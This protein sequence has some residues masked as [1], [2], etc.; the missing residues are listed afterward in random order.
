M[1]N[2]FFKRYRWLLIVI[3]TLAVYQYFRPLPKAA[4]QLDLPMTP[5]VQSVNLAWPAGGQAALGAEGYGL[6]ASHNGQQPAP[7]GSTA[8]IITALAILEQ[9]PI[10]AGGQGPTLTL[11]QS[12]VD[13][14]NSYY[15]QNGSVTN[16]AAGEQI[17]EYQALESLLIPSS[18]NM[19]DTLAAWA[20]GSKNAYLR[21][22]NQ[23]VKNIGLQ[24]TTV[25]DTNGFSDTTTSTADDLVKL[26]LVAIKNPVF[27]DV[28]GKTIAQ[29][30]VEGTIKNTNFLL[31][32]SGIIGIKTGHTDQAGGNYVFAA[33]Q[34]IQGHQITLVGA[35]LNQPSIN[36]AIQSSPKL[37]DSANRGFKPFTVKKDQI[38]GLYK[39]P[40][41]AT[42]PFKSAKELSMLVWKGSNVQL[43]SHPQNIGPV[44]VGTKVGELKITDLQ[45]S[46]TIDLVLAKNLSSPSPF[47][48]L[49]R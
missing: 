39:S 43:T 30:P 5:P 41:G 42:A 29:I 32:S 14:F 45:Q 49:H 27:A 19:A 18:N 46:A 47:W 2:R 24:H 3:V 4:P 31:G 37:I 12:D 44:S 21:Y 15:S 10:L 16:V 23:M 33:K 20:F 38:F 48:R 9:K 28:V 17:T 40:W 22:A 11:T 35:I 1:K 26:G 8:K 25:G 13:L 34:T 36:D 6:L 7:I